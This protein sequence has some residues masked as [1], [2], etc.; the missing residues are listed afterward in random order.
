VTIA[1]YNSAQ[2]IH[3]ALS[4]IFSSDYPA[5]SFEVVIADGGSSDGTLD[6]AK[7]FPV[8][9]YSRPNASVGSRRNLSIR[10]SK[11]EIVCCV[12]SDIVVPNDWL[13]KISDY[14]DQHPEVDG[15]GGPLFPPS[16]SKNDIQ[17]YTG[18]LYF[19][20]QRCPTQI[21][22]IDTLEYQTLLPTANSAFRK[23][24]FLSVGGF[25]EY[26]Y[27]FTID[28]P[29]MWNMVSKNCLLMFLPDLAVVHLGF[30]TTLS[31]VVK[32]QF[33][34]G[35]NK[36]ILRKKYPYKISNIVQNLKAQAYPTFQ[37]AGAFISLISPFKYPKK[38]ELLR[39]CHYTSFHLGRLYGRGAKLSS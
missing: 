31:G 15:V 33:R 2:T 35:K 5:K 37:I 23:E 38:K 12:D 24:V 19:E 1:T 34:W 9:I 20:D 25:P 4:S 30:P 16:D 22:Q 3:D 11:G 28:M 17:K 13:R 10:E 21:T 18:E 8:R 39:F 14:F 32:Q 6:I 36:T 7:R 27:L 29:L 26:P